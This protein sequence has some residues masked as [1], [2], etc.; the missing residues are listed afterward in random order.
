M[1]RDSTIIA[2][3][4]ASRRGGPGCTPTPCLAILEG[5]VLLA[6]KRVLALRDTFKIAA[7]NLSL[8]TRGKLFASAVR[9]D[10]RRIDGRFRKPGGPPTSLPSSDAPERR[11]HPPGAEML[12]KVVYQRAVAGG[13]PTDLIPARWRIDLLGAYNYLI[14]PVGV[15]RGWGFAAKTELT[16]WTVVEGPW[17]STPPPPAPMKS[18]LSPPAGTPATRC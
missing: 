12:R 5:D 18:V 13:A 1:A 4:V 9:Y 11:R 14:G 17:R 6:L 10:E 7:V 15:V 3:K 16:D 2:I 8:T